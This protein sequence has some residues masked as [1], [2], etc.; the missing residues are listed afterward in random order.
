MESIGDI[1]KRTQVAPR[2]EASLEEVPAA[3]C[4]LCEGVGFL[5]HAVP[6]DHPDFGRAFPCQ[7]TLQEFEVRY[8]A[9][10]PRGMTFSDFHPEPYQLKALHQANAYAQGKLETPWLVLIGGLGTGKTHLAVAVLHEMASTG[11]FGAFWVVAD[12]LD[13]IRQGIGEEEGQDA[14]DRING[15]I[16]IAGPLALDDW[17]RH[18]MSAWVEEELFRLVDARYRYRRPT[19]ITTNLP[20]SVWPEAL[21][22]RAM[23]RRVSTVVALTGPSYRTG[24]SY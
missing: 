22:D 4:P 15:L 18:T 5:R 14:Q 13:W 7:C 12:L 24:K 11:Q 16:A 9:S 10:L 3:V 2:V 23:D 8:L 21:L 19:I 20:R 1:I 17:G 6:L